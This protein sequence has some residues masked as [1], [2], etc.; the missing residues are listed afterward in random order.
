MTVP[1]GT[2]VDQRYE[3]LHALG[4]GS[5][6][7][8]YEV[9][10][11]TQGQNVALKLLN[12]ATCGEWPWLE[13][14]QLT[15]LRSDYIL[16]VWNASI[17]GGIPYVV[18]EVAAAGAADKLLEL[19]TGPSLGTS[20]RTIRHGCRGAARAHDDG[21]LHRDIKL[22]NLFVDAN[23]DT[24]LGDFGLAFPL[25]N[26]KAPA[27]GTPSTMA[28]ELFT[29]G[30]ATVLS[31]IYSLGCSLYKLLTGYYPYLD[32]DPADLA[33]FTQL[34]RTSYPTPLRDLA[35]Q[36]GR[37]LAKCVETSLS[38][39]PTDRFRSAADFDAALGAM[40]A[41]QRDWFVTSP[42]AGH[43]RCWSSAPTGGAVKVC[44]VATST[45][46]RS[47]IEVTRASSGRRMRPLCRSGLTNAALAGALRRTFERLEN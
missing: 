35:P 47:D 14:V 22:E 15:R 34:V 45:Y 2:L 42:H 12:P 5:F 41:P 25:Q 31:D 19:P 37:S 29:G 44:V 23:G 13:A 39:E 4:E 43:R 38:R 40:K 46:A 11:H 33:E 7:E 10:D 26:G 27:N 18:T 36:V 32:A 24:R 21:V 8:V 30:D 17:V 6:G 1:R 28:P 20:V 3:I 9:L 16:P